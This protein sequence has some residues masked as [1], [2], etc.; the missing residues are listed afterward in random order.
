MTFDPVTLRQPGAPWTPWTYETH[1]NEGWGMTTLPCGDYVV[2]DGSSWLFVW[3]GV[4]MEEKRRFKVTTSNGKAVKFLNELEYYKG[5]VLANI[6][7]SDM[8]VRIN[9]D[10]GVVTAVYDFS[11]LWPAEERP[12]TADCFNGIAVMEDDEVL[13]TGKLWEE[14]FVV[15]IEEP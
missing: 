14:Y 5:S 8:I 4:T 11:D 3:D 9:V 10:T 13:V 7:Y 6:W 2:S 15:K 1:T 12:R